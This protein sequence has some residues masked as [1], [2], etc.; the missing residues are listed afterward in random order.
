MIE[1][2]AKVVT[3]D[4]DTIWLDVERQSTCSACKVKS[5]CGTGLLEK[6]VGQRFSRIAVKN[7]KHINVVAGQR[8]Q[9]SISEQHLLKSAMTM[10]L[11]PLVMLFIFAGMTSLLDVSNALEI[12]SGLVGLSVGLLIVRFYFKGKEI[13]I[14]A[15][16]VEAS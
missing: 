2:Q 16:V 3:T 8:M 10:Y 12:F 14:D 5:G 13:G 6:H 7:D 4:R 9:V 15:K 11:V 1:Q